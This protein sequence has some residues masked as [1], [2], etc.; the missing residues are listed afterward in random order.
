MCI[1]VNQGFNKKLC[2]SC[3]LF[4]NN[5]AVSAVN[6]CL[7]SE[8]QIRGLHHLNFTE[9][10]QGRREAETYIYTHLVGQADKYSK[11]EDKH[12]AVV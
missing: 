8:A 11:Q 7:V 1:S 5:V 6:Y 2:R 4:A 12:V 3:C 9:C 10:I